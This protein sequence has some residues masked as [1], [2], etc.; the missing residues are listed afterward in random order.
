MDQQAGKGQGWVF[1]GSIVGAVLLGTLIAPHVF[2]GLLAL[3]RANPGLSALRNL[4]FDSVV[5]RCV[6]L[7][8]VLSLYPAIR[9]T[10]MRNLSAFGFVRDG[11][12]RQDWWRGVW[13]GALSLILVVL[14]GYLMGAY[15]VHV[16]DKIKDLG[17]ILTVIVGAILVGFFEEA[18]FR[19]LL[20]GGLRKSMRFWPAAVI[21]SLLFMLVHFARPVPPIMP[22]YGEWNSGLGMLKHMFYTGHSLD[23]Y[24]PFMLTLFLMGLV[25]CLTYVRRGSILMAVGLHTGWVLIIR[26][27]GYLFNRDKEQWPLLFSDGEVISQTYLTLLVAVVFL[28]CFVRSPAPKSA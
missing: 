9:V 19:G 10:G 27:A 7:C 26:F 24:F 16:D 11:R 3:G 2:N 1:I 13:M 17:K 28:I 23:N 5:G 12:G 21:S 8:L 4:E 18:L 25:L 15:V 20:F 22:V 6:I 14:I